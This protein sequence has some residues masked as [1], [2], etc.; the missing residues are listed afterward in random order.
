M[1]PPPVRDDGCFY[2]AD[3]DMMTY[4]QVL[5]A[6]V[7]GAAVG[8][9]TTQLWYGQQYPGR[10]LFVEISNMREQAIPLL[11]IEHGNDFSQ[12][13]IL[14]TQ[15]QPG[16]TRII[17]LNHEPGKGYSVEAQLA[18]GKKTEAC[19]GKLSTGWVNRVVITSNGVFSPD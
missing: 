6:G 15:L 16:E 11:K 8:A 1:L 2:G 18:D 10:P 12:E 17:T 7:T 19:V 9:F 5:L 4:R 13:K 14:L 3:A